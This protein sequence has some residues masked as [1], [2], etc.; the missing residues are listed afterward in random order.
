MKKTPKV[1]KPKPFYANIYLD[2]RAYGGPEEGGWYYNYSEVCVSV[3]ARSMREANT[4][5]KRLTKRRYSNEGRRPIWSVNSRGM[6]RPEIE[7]KP[8]QDSSDYQ[9]W[10]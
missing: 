7:R 8:A 3:K 1:R 5:M 9:P 2:D 4:I 6:Y 10:E